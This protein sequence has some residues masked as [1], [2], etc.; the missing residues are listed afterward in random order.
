MKYKQGELTEADIK[1][2][3][4]LWNKKG[5]FGT[6]T[7]KERTRKAFQENATVVRRYERLHEGG[8]RADKKDGPE[9]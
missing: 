9:H 5:F 1:E 3:Q 8:N 2:R 7:K 6:P 4:R